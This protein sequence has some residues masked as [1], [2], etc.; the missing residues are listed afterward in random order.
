MTTG[1]DPTISLYALDAQDI[2]WALGHLEDWLL[3]ADP[4]TH[5]DLN[6]FCRGTSTN[7]DHL[8]DTLGH[9]SILIHRQLRAIN[10]PGAAID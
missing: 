2:A 4:D 1:P 7:P 8:I 10:P 9:L 5:R 3:H 6:E